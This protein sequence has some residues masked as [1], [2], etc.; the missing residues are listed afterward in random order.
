M[1]NPGNRGVF[2]EQQRGLEAGRSPGATEQAAGIMG[3]VKDKASELASNVASTAE[4]AWDATRQT[5]Q[6]V[7]STVASTAEDAWDSM[8]SFMR[9]YPIATFC[10][11]AGF[12]FLLAEL[13]ASRRS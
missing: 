2:S 11:G 8:S 9:R 7:A 1:A 13:F 10:I 4:Q 3:T 12:G 6:N 5:A